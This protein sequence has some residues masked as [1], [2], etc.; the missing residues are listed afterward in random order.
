MSDPEFINSEHLFG[1]IDWQSAGSK[2]CDQACESVEQVVHRYTDGY[3]NWLESTN[4][5]DMTDC[6]CLCVAVEDMQLLIARITELE[7]IPKD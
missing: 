6:D 4:A 3:D 1:N 7:A 2:D 5:E